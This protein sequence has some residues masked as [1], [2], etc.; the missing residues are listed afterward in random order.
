MA[1]AP[2]S[3]PKQRTFFGHPSMLANLFSVEMWERFSFYGMQ[4][5]MLLYL[6]S[7]IDKG[8]LG[9]EKATAAGII[10]A[11]GGTV[12]LMAIL[13]SVLGDRL[14]GPERALFYSAITIMVGHA[15]LALVP[16]VAGVAIGLILV[17]VGSG[18]LKTNASALVASLYKDGD[19]LR[20]AGFTIFYIGVNTGAFF[21]PLLTGWL[22]VEQGFH[23]A[24]GAA[25]IGMA[26]GLIQYALTRKNL[27]ASVHEVA[28]PF[29]PAQRNGFYASLVAIIAVIA[30]AVTFGI[31]TP[32]NL[33]NW[34]MGIIALAA[35]ALFVQMLSS[36]KVTGE[37]RSRVYAFIPLWIA[38]AVF[39][40]L[41]QQQFTVIELYAD[42]RLNRHVG[43]WEMP[44]EWVN[45]I[46]PVFIMIFG[47]V[48]TAI[49][50]KMG[51][52]Q[53][54]STTKFSLGLVLLGAGF[55]LFI[56]QQGVASVALYWIVLILFVIT[57]AEL[58]FSPIGTSFATKIAPKQYRVSMLALYFTS[59]AMGTVL[60]GWFAQ[61][62]SH[63]N[64]VPYFVAMGVLAIGTGVLLA[65]CHKPLQKLMA[66]VR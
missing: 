10:G 15:A 30:L 23:M 35:V 51:E 8:G 55:L 9:I 13:G 18:V 50:T 43:S 6:Y 1:T 66:G 14:I 17:A 41:Y 2:I 26:L 57:I 47:V 49:W 3:A 48:F 34:V 33:K 20:D 21:G 53:P 19:P 38:N 64:E 39:F 29:T 63:E 11:Y 65:A 16:G 42:E 32:A 56:T 54:S 45:S 31:V 5:V 52:R 37:E 4:V 44:T 22:R 27:P 46:N 7:S 61:F 24:F 36:K 60:S 59:V 40:G 28:N 25:A 12:Y 58:V 62:Y